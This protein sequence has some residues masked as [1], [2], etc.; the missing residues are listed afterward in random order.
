VWKEAHEARWALYAGFVVLIAMPVLQ[1]AS[2]QAGAPPAGTVPEARAQ[3][4]ER[5][6]RNVL[7]ASVT[8]VAGAFGWSEPD[9]RAVLD[10]AN[11]MAQEERE[12]VEL[13]KAWLA[14]VPK[15]EKDWDV[16]LD[17][18]NVYD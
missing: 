5:F 6:L 2:P 16:D 4:A 8:E 17:P 1:A 12:H 18:P 11:E 9:A 10:A 15:P 7:V 14:R 3:V 13:V